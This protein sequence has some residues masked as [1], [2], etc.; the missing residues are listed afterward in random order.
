MRLGLERCWAAPSSAVVVPYRAAI[1]LSV[2][3]LATRWDFA[4]E[5]EEGL[6]LEEPL[7]EE[8]WLEDL[9]GI[10]RDCPIRIIA[11][12]PRL[13]ASMIFLTLVLYFR[14]RSH[15][16]SPD[17]TLWVSE[18]LF[19]AADIASG[20]IAPRPVPRPPTPTTP[21][22]GEAESPEWFS[23][24]GRRRSS[25]SPVSAA[26]APARA[27]AVA[28]MTAPVVCTVRS[29]RRAMKTPARRLRGAQEVLE[30]RETKVTIVVIR[31]SSNPFR[32]LCDSDGGLLV[33]SDGRRSELAE[34]LILLGGQVEGIDRRLRGGRA[35]G[36]ELL[37][38]REGT[39]GGQDLP[40]LHHLVL[41]EVGVADPRP[42]DLDLRR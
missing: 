25:G 22:D 31:V 13:F 38:L 19:I 16:V 6:E 24:G 42:E 8:P 32:K 41:G 9:P 34:Q 29:L 33:A 20:L 4:E 23:R 40:H 2:S 37:H 39:A 17:F 12:E 1:P 10:V 36:N 30:T 27:I 7:E 11:F 35:L 5:P 21:C 28:P 14:A 15:T 18:D 3:P 26:G